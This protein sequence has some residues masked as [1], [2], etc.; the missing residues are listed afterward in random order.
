MSSLAREL[1]ASACEPKLL[2]AKVEAKLLANRVVLTDGVTETGQ[3]VG[4]RLLLDGEGAE[5]ALMKRLLEV[6]N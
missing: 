2:D 3:F 4:A 1:G 5:D 6:K